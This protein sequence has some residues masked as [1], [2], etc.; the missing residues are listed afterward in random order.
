MMQ[1]RNRTTAPRP[2]G[3]QQTPPSPRMS[4]RRWI[5]LIGLVILFN[6]VFYYLQLGTTSTTP[7]TT[8]SYSAFVTQVQRHNIKNATISGTDASGNFRKPYKTGGKSYTRYT[9]TI[10][11]DVIS[12]LV[13][14][15]QKEGVDVTLQN[16]T[17]PIW[18]SLLGLLL[19]A[20]PLLFLF[21]LFY[22]GARSTMQQQ[23]GIFGFGQSRAKLYTEERPTTTFADVAGVESAKRELTEEVDFLRNPTKYQ[24]LGARIPKGVLLVG[25]PG[26]GKTLL[27]RAVAGEARVPFLSISA[28][29]FVELFVGVGASRVRDLFER[30]KATAPAIVFIDEIDAIGGRRGGG[31]PMG[32]G[33]NSERE[34][35]LNQL[36]VSMDG[37]E[38]NQA[39]IVLAVTNRP[40]VLDPALLRPGRFDRQVTL[41]KPD[42]RGR[43]AIL[44]VHARGKPLDEAVSLETLAKQTPGFSGADLQNLLNEGAIL[45]ARAGK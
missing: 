24:Q 8:L 17:T 45:T 37:F 26:T 27:A 16:N 21:G 33:S 38:P 39:V 13:P 43:L 2:D 25:P 42:I 41:E 1:Q 9:T 29:E 4:A 5:T 22:F 35:T 44:D 3:Q 36:L 11:S 12:T 14:Y 18:L 34:Q 15:L 19:Q 7:Q 6:F 32:G 40:D 10:V 31:G 23:Q 30:A 28:T 20:L